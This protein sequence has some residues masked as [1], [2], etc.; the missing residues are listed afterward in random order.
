V[1][2]QKCRGLAVN[3]RDTDEQCA[4]FFTDYLNDRGPLRKTNGADARG[5]V[6]PGRGS[7]RASFSPSLFIIFPFLFL[8][9]L[10][11]L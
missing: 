10:G 4:G 1:K 8:P 6:S 7:I 3:V 11:N 2:K 9:D 5:R